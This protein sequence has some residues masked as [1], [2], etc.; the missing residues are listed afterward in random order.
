MRA[1]HAAYR[2]RGVL[3]AIGVPLLVAIAVTAPF[4]FPAGVERARGVL[5][6]LGVG[7]FAAALILAALGARLL[8]ERTPIVVRPPV[9]G[10]WLALNSPASQVP[11]HGVR[12]YGQAYAIDLVAVPDDAER[13]PFGAGGAWRSSADYPAFGAPVHAMI[14]GVVVAASDWRRDHRARSS[15]ISV[16]YM[17]VVEGSIRELGGPGF[18][19]GNHVIIRGDDGVFALVAHLKQGSAAVTVGERVEAGQ[20]VG[21]CGNSGN[22]SEPHVHAQLMDRANP[23]V[24][25]GLPMRFADIRVDDEN[26]AEGMPANGERLHA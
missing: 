17:M 3:L 15:M 14:D 13:P 7:L 10:R 8:P 18:V 21:L 1:L 25:Q 6:T 24:A 2:V 9:S 5:G 11:S 19:I 12:A 4:E 26:L 20:V 23:L 22:S 16:L